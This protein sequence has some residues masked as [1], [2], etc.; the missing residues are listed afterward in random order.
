MALL[1]QLAHQESTCDQNVYPNS[2]MLDDDNNFVDFPDPHCMGNCAQ[3]FLLS[4]KVDNFYFTSIF[5]QQK[6]GDKTLVL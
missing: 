2:S 4:S 5:I 6:F 1:S 3:Y